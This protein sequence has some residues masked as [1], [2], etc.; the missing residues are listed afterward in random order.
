MT[1]VCF[2]LRAQQAPIGLDPPV[3]L[4]TDAL[5]ND[6]M[7][8][9]IG[10]PGSSN[11][12]DPAMFQ[13]VFGSVAGNKRL[14]PGFY[15]GRRAGSVTYDCSTLPG[16]SGSVVLDVETGRAVGLHF[17]GTAFDTNFAVP[18]ADLTRNSSRRVRGSGKGRRRRS[19]FSVTRLGR[20]P[21]S[22]SA[23]Q[24]A[25]GIGAPQPTASPDGALTIVVPLEISVRL[26]VPAIATGAHASVAS[27]W[28]LP[29]R[30]DRASAEAAAEK[31]RLHLIG[32]KSVLSVKADYLFR[33]GA[34]TDDFGVVVGV[35]PGAAV[36]A[37]AHGLGNLIGGV[38]IS[39]ET[40]DPVTIAEQLFAFG[41]EAFGG[42]TANYE[43][44][45]SDE[46]FDL[47]PVEDEMT[48]GLHAL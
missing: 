39:V 4:L 2:G 26:G 7:V 45:L 29:A 23:Q 10:F 36:E 41:T 33:D 9:V 30:M 42:R 25:A 13:K 1:F 37:A 5:S 31:V 47:S 14:S 48:I 16:S 15:A 32:D 19:L 24:G 3:R 38:A 12:Y 17:A 34:I 20:T 35:V 40:A 43:R 46:R 27:D 11:G 8:A 44:D 22:S 18:V 21:G 6:R 28:Q